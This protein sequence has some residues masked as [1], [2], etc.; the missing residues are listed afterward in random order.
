MNRELPGMN[1]FNAAVT[2]VLVAELN[3]DEDPLRALRKAL[4]G[5]IFLIEDE[6]PDDLVPLLEYFITAFRPLAAYFQ[7]DVQP[8]LGE[9][10][11]QRRRVGT[12]MELLLREELL[13]EIVRG[14][15]GEPRSN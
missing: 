15:T 5:L 12:R 9:H 13:W 11:I 2:R 3:T 6:A 8:F 7:D 14:F 10:P 4:L 1:V